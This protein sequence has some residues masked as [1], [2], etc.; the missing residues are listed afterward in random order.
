MK[1]L[2]EWDEEY[3]LEICNDEYSNIEIKNR[4]LGDPTINN[5]K[6]NMKKSLGKEISAFANYDGGYL[7]L[8]IKDMKERKN[9]TDII[10]DGGIVTFKGRQSTKDWLENILPNLV[11]PQ[12]PKIDVHCINLEDSIDRAIYV[13][14][15][16]PSDQAPH[17]DV[18]S[19]SYYGRL[20]SKSRPLSHKYVADIMGRRT[21]PVL[22]IQALNIKEVYTFQNG[23]EILMRCQL[24]VKIKN[25]SK[26]IAEAYQILIELPD[27]TVPKDMEGDAIGHGYL[28]YTTEDGVVIIDNVIGNILLPLLPGRHII[29]II[30]LPKDFIKKYQYQPVQWSIYADNS[31]TKRGEFNFDNILILKSLS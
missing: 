9:E 21:N 17:Q 28:N 25:I 8:G 31:L 22:E 4:T 10:D 24:T 30:H 5:V 12:L 7:I 19:Y 23:I 29:R 3:L 27:G 20:G 2:I 18:N 15:I 13:A 11:E 16:Y 1:P 14:Q 26:V 6:N